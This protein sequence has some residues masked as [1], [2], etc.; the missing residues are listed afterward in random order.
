MSEKLTDV[1]KDVAVDVLDGDLSPEGRS[2]V[3]RL[4]IDLVV[5][6]VVAVL[7]AVVTVLVALPA[8]GDIDVPG[9]VESL[10]L[11]VVG[12]VVSYVRGRL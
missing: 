4:A 6:L 2:R 1:A 3:K 9:L 12:A 8:T 5:G 11:V 7:S 10:R